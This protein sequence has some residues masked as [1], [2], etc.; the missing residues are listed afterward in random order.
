VALGEITDG[1]D[2][3]GAD[4]CGDELLE[5]GP[6]LVD[7]PEGRV[8]RIGQVAGRLD[9]RPQHRRQVQLRA[10]GHD[11]VQEAV[12][13]GEPGVARRGAAAP[14]HAAGPWFLR[15]DHHAGPFSTATW[16][17]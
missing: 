6:L 12:E 17:R 10:D 7:D 15:C 9:H 16:P 8:L 1:P 2:G 11:G 4:A 5:M 14:G 13:L 3:L